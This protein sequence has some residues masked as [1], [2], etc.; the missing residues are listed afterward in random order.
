MSKH[1]TPR[2]LGLTVAAVMAVAV[3][4]VVSTTGLSP[5]LAQQQP[6]TD[7]IKVGLFSFGQ[8]M[9]V[10]P[11]RAEAEQRMGELQAQAQQA[12]QQQDQQGLMQAIQ[13]I[14]EAQD[15]Y[16]ARF[17]QD[18]S[19][20][21]SAVVEETGAHIVAIQIADVI[22][23][24]DLD[25]LTYTADNVTTE[26]VTNLVIR[27]ITDGELQEAPAPQLPQLQQQPQQ[28]EQAPELEF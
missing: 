7:E 18:L 26:D 15:D 27:E 16:F 11:G 5:S 8:V 24:E 10:H 2:R 17:Q 19:E 22:Q 25:T 14:E 23:V 9:D 28:Q 6:A 4:A 1:V 12:Q 20:A 21:M 13:Q 3:A